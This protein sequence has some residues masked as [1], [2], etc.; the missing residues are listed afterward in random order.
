LV[1]VSP[2]LKL[3]YIANPTI[4][5]ITPIIIK[6]PLDESSDLSS[7]NNAFM[8]L[9]GSSLVAVSCVNPLYAANNSRNTDN[10]K[11]THCFHN[12]YF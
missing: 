4:T 6:V 3:I 11:P 7:L 8:A 1:V 2:P 5:A 12:F 9:V 10:K